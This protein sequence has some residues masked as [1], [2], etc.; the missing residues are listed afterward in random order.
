MAGVTVIPDPSRHTGLSVT[1][2][3]PGQTTR[4]WHSCRRS[5]MNVELMSFAGRALGGEGGADG[6]ASRAF[7][8]EAP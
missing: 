8:G 3:C 6:T 4:M 7:A 1:L 2:S 5:D